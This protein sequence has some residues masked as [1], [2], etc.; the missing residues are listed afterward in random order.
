MCSVSHKT[1]GGVIRPRLY[2]NGRIRL[3]L[4]PPP[5]FPW[6][7][8]VRPGIRSPWPDL[9]ITRIVCGPGAEAIQMA[10]LAIELG[11]CGC[12]TC[13]PI[14]PGA[15]SIPKLHVVALDSR[16]TGVVPRPP[17]GEHGIEPNGHQPLYPGDRRLAVALDKG[18]RDH[19]VAVHGDECGV[20]IATEVTGPAAERPAEMGDGRQ[21]HDCARK[22]GATRWIQHHTAVAHHLHRKSILGRC[23]RWRRRWRRR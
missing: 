2:F 8:D 1:T 6:P 14:L 5:P 9:D 4:F 7:P 13:L 10:S 12:R 20:C 11:R 19:L 22:V 21:L 15:V 17:H 18:G 16:P 23:F 3:L